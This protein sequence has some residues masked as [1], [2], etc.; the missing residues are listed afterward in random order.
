MRRV[1]RSTSALARVGL[2]LILGGAF[3][4]LID[5]LTLGPVVDFVDC[6]LGQHPLL[7]VQR[8]RFGHHVGV[9][10]LILDMLG[11]GVCMHP[12]LLELG[13]VTVYTYGVLLAAA[14]LL[15][16]RLA[17]GAPGRGTSI[18]PG[19]WTSAS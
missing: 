3:G 11:V 4:N 10:L 1:W 19:S 17:T 7:G 8:G 14:Y 2:A 5:R 15:G 6:L 9:G 18:R 13:P 12:I 16:L